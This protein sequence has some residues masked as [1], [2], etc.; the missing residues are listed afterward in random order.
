[1]A[2]FG[3]AA[4]EGSLNSPPASGRTLTKADGLSNTEVLSLGTGPNGVLWVGYRFGGGIDRVHPQAVGV[5]IEKGVQRSG[6]DGLIYFLK[7]DQ[8]ER[9]WAGTEHGVDVWDGARWSHYDMNDGM[10]WDDCNLNAFTQ[11]AD[12]TFWIG[13]SDGLARFRPLP[14][15]APNAPLTVVFTGLSIWKDGRV[16]AS[17]SILRQP[18]QLSRRK[19][20]RAE[21]FA[22]KTK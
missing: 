6:S 13:T 17:Q 20:F 22:V 2:H 3:P 16:R 19:V 11:E 9:L 5:A 12:G 10:V 8:R 4:P 18:F 15:Q 7:F 14:R 1:M 21:C